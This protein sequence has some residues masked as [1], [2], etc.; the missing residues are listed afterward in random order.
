MKIT[1]D[2][3]MVA[4]KFENDPGIYWY[5][6]GGG[7]RPFATFNLAQAKREVTKLRKNG[8]EASIVTVSAKN[9]TCFLDL[10]NITV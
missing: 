6:T 7:E 8:Y 9:S 4:I 2:V 1:S 3:Y 5:C 10:N